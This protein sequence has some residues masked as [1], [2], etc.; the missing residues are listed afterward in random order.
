MLHRE[1]SDLD[2]ESVEIAASIVVDVMTVVEM[3]ISRFPP[4]SLLE[5]YI[6]YLGRRG[7]MELS[8]RPLARY[9]SLVTDYGQKHLKQFYAG[10]NAQ[11]VIIR[12]VTLTVTP[13]RIR[14]SHTSITPDEIEISHSPLL[15][16]LVSSG[17]DNPTQLSV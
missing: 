1:A 5:S 14:G 10:P 7:C 2:S 15:E 12:I 11:K 9:F 13:L 16:S 3:A 8:D 6:T 4:Q 17:H